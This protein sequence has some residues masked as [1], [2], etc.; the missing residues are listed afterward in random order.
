[1]AK[2]TTRREAIKTG[3]KGAAAVGGAI[4]AGDAARGVYED[5][6]KKK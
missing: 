2:E 6:K 1:M 4:L 5:K 3:L